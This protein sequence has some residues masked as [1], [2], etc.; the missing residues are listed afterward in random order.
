MT[1]KIFSLIIISVSLSAIAQISLKVGMSGLSVQSAMSESG[2]GYK[3]FLNIFTN[4]Y[5]LAGL[6]MYVLGAVLWLFVLARVDVSM[7]YPYVGIGF[8]IT[9][10]LGSALLGEVLSPLRVVGTLLVVGGITLISMQPTP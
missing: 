10:L 7:A 9:M 5:V 8:I 4:L 3:L 2:M 6:S 1:I